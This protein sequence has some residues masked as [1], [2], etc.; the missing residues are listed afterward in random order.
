MKKL[1]GCF[2]LV[3]AIVAFTT[4]AHA[5][6][7]YAASVAV[8]DDEVF[9]GE[10]GNVISSGF[11]YIYRPTADG[12]KEVGKLAA[13]DAVDRDRFGR[14]TFVDGDLLL[15]GGGTGTGKVYV[16]ER[17]GGEW[18]EVGAARRTFD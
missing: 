17:D 8:G 4:A 9:V 15:V 7:G 16:F 6:S 5:Q 13:S 2:A 1:F 3:F 11:V 12:W 10:A 14:S 18:A